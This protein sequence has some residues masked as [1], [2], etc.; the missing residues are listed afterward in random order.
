MPGITEQVNNIESSMS[1]S[2]ELQSS[3]IEHMDLPAGLPTEGW[4]YALKNKFMPGIYKVGMTTNEPEI[5]ANQISQGTGIPAPFEVLFAYFSECPKEHEQQIHEEL[6]E[7]RISPNREFFECDEEMITDA[8]ESIGLVSRDSSVEVVANQYQVVCLEV[9]DRYSL[10]EML[11][12]LDITVFGCRWAAVKRLVELAKMSIDTLDRKG[13]S[14]VFQNG[15]A[16]P[17]IRDDFRRRQEYQKALNEAGAYG[18]KK[19][20]SF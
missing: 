12:D 11:D 15:Q 13:C 1:L 6:S 9:D 7:R 10:D 3:A 5:R 14:L 18:P 19:P 16:I 2:L 17:I 4:V 8:F 20:W